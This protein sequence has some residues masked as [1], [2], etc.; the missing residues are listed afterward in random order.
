MQ[1]LDAF[2]TATQR[3]SF[4]AADLGIQMM[5]GQA[6]VAT[7]GAGAVGQAA[8][9][10]AAVVAGGA[11]EEPGFWGSTWLM[12]AIW[13]GVFVLMYFIMFRPQRKREKLM[14]EMQDSVKTGDNIVTSG[15]LFGRV[16]DVGTDSLVIEFGISGRS[17]KIPVL[18]GDV[19]GLREPVLTPPPKQ[20]EDN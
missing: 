9:G 8:A 20:T 15:G 7:D 14:R 17:V 6:P 12:L 4:L 13:G 1:M 18:K 10:A 2:F 3:F 11:V 5:P 19:I 16:A